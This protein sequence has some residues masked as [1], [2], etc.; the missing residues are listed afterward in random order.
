MTARKGGAASPPETVSSPAPPGSPSTLATDPY[1]TVRVNKS[2]VAEIK[3]ALDDIVKVH[4]AQ[5][6]FTPS[7]MHTNVH[8]TLGYAS[9]FFA[10]GCSLYAYKMD[11]EESKPALWIAVVGYFG[12]QGALWAWKRW[13]ERGEVFRGRRRRIVKRIETDHIQIITSTTLQHPP[14]R[15][16]SI[17]PDSRPTSPTSPTTS[18][19]SSSSS[20]SGLSSPPHTPTSGVNP[21]PRGPTYLVHLTLSTTSNSGKSLIHKARVV[22]GKPIGEVVDEDG[23]VEAGEVTRWISTLL[24]DA[25]MVGVEE[26][27]FKEE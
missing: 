19:L 14:T 12:F 17:S 1:P 18:S 24:N 6:A 7:H 3:T 2:H 22:S 13:V 23:G 27:G 11:F 21:H 4:L 16:V 9:V 15:V 25:G 26:E 8:L 20:V 5:Q 10:L